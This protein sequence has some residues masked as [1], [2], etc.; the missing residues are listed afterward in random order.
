MACYL[1]FTVMITYKILFK[2]LAESFFKLF[3][4]SITKTRTKLEESDI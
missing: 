1:G 4:I 3:I 2:H